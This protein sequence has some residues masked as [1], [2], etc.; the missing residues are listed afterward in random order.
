M[1][2]EPDITYPYLFNYVKG[3]EWR[4]QKEVRRLIQTYFKNEPAGLPGNDDTGTLSTWLVYSMMG[5]YP[6]CPG[7]MNYA[8]SSPVFDKVIIKLNPEFYKNKQLIIEALNNKPGNNYIQSIAINGK[9]LKKYFIN[10]QDLVKTEK[11]SFEL[12]KK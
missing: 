10:H 3:Q 1:A 12:I 5:F 6:V 2:N 7:D 4:T 8:L 9:S 11:L